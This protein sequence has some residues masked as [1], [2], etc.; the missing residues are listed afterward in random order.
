[1]N[2]SNTLETRLAAHVD[3]ARCAPHPDAVV[4]RGAARFC[5][6][7][8]RIVRLEWDA[9]AR[10][11]DR[12]TLAILD[13]RL[14][15]VSDFTVEPS[16]NGL[17]IR[18]ASL[19]LQWSDDG[20][21]FSAGN[22]AIEYEHGGRWR[23]W[24]PGDPTPLLGGTRRDLDFVGRPVSPTAGIL[25][26]EGCALLDDTATFRFGTDGWAEPPLPA[27]DPPRC[28]WYFFGH[29]LDPAHAL[30]AFARLSRPAPLPPLYALGAWFSRYRP[31]CADDLLAIADEFRRR[32]FPLDILV[33]D[34]DWH[35]PDGWTGYTWNRALFPNPPA[36]LRSLH[37]R[38]LH[39]TL[40]L[41]PAEGIRPHEAIYPAFAQAMGLDP[42]H[43]EGIPFRISDRTYARHYFDLL[44]HPLE[45]DGVDFWWVDWQHGTGSD[46]PGLDPL[47][48]LNHLHWTDAE[49]RP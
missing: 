9:Q 16:P 5:V 20:L 28:D 34:M 38:G 1:M 47:A 18:T 43:R 17:T 22:L 30:A 29:G 6:L 2:H 39:T 35:T 49:R 10:F 42:E 45:R 13:R 23:T 14:D 11:D 44:H 48:W 15:P 3:P 12:P 37:E 21:A 31:Y 7:T 32:G 41:H 24:R 46:I 4:V 40:N 33:V 19:R 26:R 36:F 8:E 27:G 25:G